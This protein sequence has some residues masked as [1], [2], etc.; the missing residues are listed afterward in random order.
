MNRIATGVMVVAAVL[1]AAGALTVVRISQYGKQ[2]AGKDETRRM[3]LI[4]PGQ[5][6]AATTRLL[7]EAKVIR[8]P[9][10]FMIMVRVKGLDKKI[11]S[12]EY[13]FAATM[14][15]IQ[16]IDRLVHG[17]VY[18]HR[19]TVPE[20]SDI[21]QVARLI[22]EAGIGDGEEFI[23]IATDAATAAS[24]RIQAS[25]CEGYLFPDTYFFPR[26]LNPR[27]IVETMVH[28]FWDVFIPEW[29]ERAR[30][31]NLSLHQIVTLASI[32]EKETGTESERP[33]VS[34]VF[35]NRLRRNM[36]LESDPTVI[37]GVPE[38]DGNLTKEHLKTVTAYNTYTIDGLPEGPITNPG[39][40]ALKAALFP[41]DTPFF[42]FV[43]KRDRTHEF[44]T[45]YS[46][47][48]RAVYK[49]QIEG[50]D[51]KATHDNKKAKTK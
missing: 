31:L 48:Q 19:L 7:A 22:A 35:H 27:K 4:P 11:Q 6:L 20:G 15:P 32:I 8:H 45:T 12:G 40:E 47:H 23:R 41:A 42:Y 5:T 50:N 26:G 39:K 36:R 3:L 46:D 1:V 25:G 28:R 9:S 30:T 24:L 38:F 18:L 44:S 2:P 33:I 16:I 49:Y 17:K 34:S 13:D 51:R 10:W 43:S 21:R 37:Y 29:Q 14:S